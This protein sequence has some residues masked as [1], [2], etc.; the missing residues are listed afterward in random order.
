MGI[1]GNMAN[2]LQR[3]GKLVA[4]T[5]TTASIAPTSVAAS[6]GPITLTVTGTG[7]TAQ[8]KIVWRAAGSQGDWVELP[9]TFGSATSISTTAYDPTAAGSYSIAVR[10]APGQAPTNAQTSTVT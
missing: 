7:F 10:V 6:A 8:S 9:T 3:V 1:A 4:S 2:V 5:G